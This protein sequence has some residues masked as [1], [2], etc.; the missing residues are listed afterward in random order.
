M[1][2]KELDNLNSDELFKVLKG[3]C[4]S[5]LKRD[6]YGDII[7]LALVIL[8]LAFTWQKLDDRK[9]FSYFMFWIPFVCFWGWLMLND[10]R[11][12]KKVDSFASPNRL[13]Y[14]FEKKHR[15]RMMAWLVA[16]IFS[17]MHLLPFL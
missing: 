9:E 14:C 10:F 5:I 4:K 8:L 13:L 1:E 3:R 11:F 12:L 16:C 15:Y 17:F 6:L 2:T 7:I